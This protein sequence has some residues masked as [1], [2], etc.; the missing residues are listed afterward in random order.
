M[1]KVKLRLT[2]HFQVRMQE[3]NIQIEHVK[4]AIR[5]PDLK[6]AVF[7]GRTRVRKK[8]GSKTI[9]VVYWKDGFRDKSNEYIISTAY[10]L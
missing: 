10:Y 1:S 5:D 6:E 8:I 7:E 2:N 4:K 3:R 9:V